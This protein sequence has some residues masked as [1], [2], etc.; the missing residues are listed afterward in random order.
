METAKTLTRWLS[1]GVVA[2]TLTIGI[3]VAWTTHFLYTFP[4]SHIPEQFDIGFFYEGNSHDSCGIVAHNIDEA[5]AKEIIRQGSA[6]FAKRLLSEQRHWEKWNKTPVKIRPYLHSEGTQF[7]G[8]PGYLKVE[9]DNY[10][11]TPGSYFSY[12]DE[13]FLL[14]HPEKQRVILAHYY[15]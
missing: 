5:T 6:Y 15:R 10:I 2:L 4:S 3:P 12:F 14:V 11:A 7:C 8:D 13:G 1:G 9:L